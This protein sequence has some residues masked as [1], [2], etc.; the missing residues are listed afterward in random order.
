MGHATLVPRARPDT[1]LKRRDNQSLVVNRARIWYDTGKAAGLSVFG[2]GQGA[3]AAASLLAGAY[4]SSTQ[5]GYQI[6]WKSFPRFYESIGNHRFQ[7]Q[8]SQFVVT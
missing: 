1:H 3:D 6:N 8:N 4:S 7:K 5:A 2:T